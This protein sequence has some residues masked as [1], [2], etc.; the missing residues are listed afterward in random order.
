MEGAKR[1]I[2]KGK[3]EKEKKQPI[4][5]EIIKQLMEFYGT[6]ENLK[7]LRFLVICLIGFS[8]FF[9]ISELLQ[10]QIKN[11]EFTEQGIKIKI[12]KS[13]TDQLREGN[14][15]FISK[16]EFKYCPTTWL[17][18]YLRLA[19]LRN[20]PDVFLVC[21]LSKTKSNLRST[22]RVSNIVYHCENIQ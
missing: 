3:S 12:P 15:V 4:T 13:K 11:I 20:Q 9:R 6:S 7:V 2:S 14:I 5:P 22:Q 19:S 17:E 18:K 8:G 1:I 21:R 16:L 10:I